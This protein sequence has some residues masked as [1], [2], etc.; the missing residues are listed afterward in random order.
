[1]AEAK[2]DELCKSV[3]DDIVAKIKE[4]GHAV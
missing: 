2:T 1:M 3:V 4:Q